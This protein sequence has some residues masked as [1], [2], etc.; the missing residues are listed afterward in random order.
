MK[1]R[2]KPFEK[3]KAG[4]KTIESRLYDKKRRQIKIGDVIVFKKHPKLEE[5]IETE[6]VALLNY[7]TF[8]KLMSDFPPEHFGGQDKQELLEELEQ[9][10]SLEDQRGN[11]VLGI[12]LQL[13]GS[14]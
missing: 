3:I 4:T 10:Y 1:L 14:E 5:T 8:A 6:V 9:F 13:A 2:P 11:T 12:K 7:T